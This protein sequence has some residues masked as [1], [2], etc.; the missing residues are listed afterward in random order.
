MAYITGENLIAAL[1]KAH[2]NFSTSNCTQAKWEIL[3]SGNSDHYAIIKPGDSESEWISVGR[4]TVEHHETIIQ[5]WQRY[6][7]DGTSATN[8]YGYVDNV[9]DQIRNN[10][11]LGDTSG[12][13]QHSRI[14]GRREVKE[15]WKKGG[16]LEWIMREIVV[17]WDEQVTAS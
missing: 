2:A 12:I 5:V 8:L 13:V 9:C 17:A 1:V 3:D 15:M 4:V 6:V 10:E 7:D 11:K 14:A 16:G